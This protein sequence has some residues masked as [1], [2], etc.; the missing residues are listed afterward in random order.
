MLL[1]RALPSTIRELALPECRRTGEHSENEKK[2]YCGLAPVVTGAELYTSARRM[3]CEGAFCGTY[4]TSS[5]F[6]N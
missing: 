3:V 5:F 4:A 1:E 6:P 2:K